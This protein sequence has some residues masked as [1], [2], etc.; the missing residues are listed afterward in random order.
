MKNKN[1]QA[2]KQIRLSPHMAYNLK[3]DPKRLAFVLAR[4]AFAAQMTDSC[5]SIL[6]LGCS[7]GI[8]APMLHKGTKK[9]LGLDLDTPAIE[10]AEKNFSTESVRFENTNFLGLQESFFDAVVSLD[11]IEH[12]LHGKDEDAFFKTISDNIH[13]DGI[14]VIGTPNATSTPYASPESQKGHVN[15]FDANRLK[16][17][18][19]KYFKT[20]LIFSMNDEIVHTGYYPMSHYLFAVGCNKIEQG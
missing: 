17:T 2:D 6:E 3:K 8:G 15:M 7:E 11:V 13:S 12:I 5:E 14:C 10:A 19:E 4:Y 9:Y 20:V 18:V 16:S 1:K